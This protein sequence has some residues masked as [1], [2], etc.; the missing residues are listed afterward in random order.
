MKLTPIRRIEM[1]G[2]STYDYWDIYTN[3]FNVHDIGGTIAD[4]NESDDFFIRCIKYWGERD[5]NTPSKWRCNVSWDKQ[6]RIYTHLTSSGREW[7]YYARTKRLVLCCPGGSSTFAYRVLAKLTPH[8]EREKW[9]GIGGEAEG[10]SIDVKFMEY[11]KWKSMSPR[12]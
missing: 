10:P 1:T 12:R 5:K 4:L 9:R 6:K 11:Q 3:I 8:L 2:L 7:K